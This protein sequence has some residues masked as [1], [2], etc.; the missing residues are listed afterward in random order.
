MRA[1]QS[2]YDAVHTAALHHG[3]QDRFGAIPALCDERLRVI[4]LQIR[5]GP[6]RLVKDVARL[7]RSKRKKPSHTAKVYAIVRNVLRSC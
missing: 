7:L 6:C 5:G 4:W 3:C 2:R 1:S